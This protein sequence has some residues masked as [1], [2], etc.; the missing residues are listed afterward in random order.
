MRQPVVVIGIG[1]LGGVF[2]RGFLRSGRPVHP[3]IRGTNLTRASIDM[4]HPE[5]VLVA[6][7]E[8]DLHDTLEQIPSAWRSRLCLLQNELLPRDWQSHKL[9]PPT[10]I[11]VWFE[12]KKGSDSKVLLPS[13]VYGPHADA[14]TSA[15]NAVSIPACSLKSESDLLFE[16][17]RK[18]VYI[19]TINIAGLVTGGSVSELWREHRRLARAVADDIISIQEW[20]VGITLERDR[21]IEGMLEAFD[22]DPDHQC[23]GRTARPRLQRAL[24]HADAAQLAVPTLRDIHTRSSIG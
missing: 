17:V 15:L 21:L 13:P 18:N 3:I 4:P 6:V 1:E 16:L 5:F 8:N 7:A 10:V 12:K 24:A 22:A 11:V 20:L 2:A 19:L 14:I 23:L 9:E